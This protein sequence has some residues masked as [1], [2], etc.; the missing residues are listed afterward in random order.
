VGKPPVVAAPAAIANAVAA[1]VG[2]RFTDLPITGEAVLR[3]LRG[4]R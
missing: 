2:H 1:A 3:A 4:H